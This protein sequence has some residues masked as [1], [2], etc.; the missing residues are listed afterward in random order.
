MES[1]HKLVV[2]IAS[3]IGMAIVLTV[4]GCVYLSTGETKAAI[5]AGLQ[6]HQRVGNYGTYW[7][8]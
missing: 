4:L 6:E 1:E 2:W 3:V 7:A 8:K 5:A